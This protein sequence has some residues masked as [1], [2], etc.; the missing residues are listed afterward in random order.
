MSLRFAGFTIL[1]FIFSLQS[2][3]QNDDEFSLVREEDSIYIYER[4]II[5]PDSDPP[6]NAREV[7]GEFLINTSIH[8]AFK[9]LK[10][11]NKIMDWQKHVTEFKVYPMPTDTAWREYSYHDIPW[12]VSDQDH[13]LIYCI[14]IKEKDKMFI[15]FKSTYDEVVSPE[16]HGVTRM[17]LLGSWTFQKIS[18]SKIKATYRI[19]SQPSSIPRIFTDPVIRRNLMSTIKSYIE[20]LE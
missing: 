2:I 1:G 3:A 18:D 12:P 7:K 4:W 8:K 19:I 17:N 9:L 6:Q 15:T 16:R 20:I 11:E 10:D 13:F 14:E 5:F